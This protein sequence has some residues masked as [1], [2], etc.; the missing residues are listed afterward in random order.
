[1]KVKKVKIE[2]LKQDPD[3]VRIHDERNI[4]AIKASL[5]KFGQQKPIVVDKNNMVVAGNGTLIACQKLGWKEI[6]IVQSELTGVDLVAYGIADNRTGELAVWDDE[7]LLEVMNLLKI[8]ETIDEVVTGFS[9]QEIEVFINGMFVDLDINEDE[10]GFAE[11]QQFGDEKG[12]VFEVILPH[13]KDNLVSVK[14]E[15][16]LLCEKHNIEYKVKKI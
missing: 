4:H 16:I 3:N 10:D 13:G 9:E 1:M 2:T 15:L 12:I 8:D 7:K 11:G 14:S 5:K 6:D